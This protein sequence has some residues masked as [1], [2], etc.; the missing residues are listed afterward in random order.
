MTVSELEMETISSNESLI[1]CLRKHHPAAVM[2]L[3]DD[4][5][6]TM[7]TRID[8]ESLTPTENI[9]IVNRE[10]DAG[11]LLD[12][13]FYADIFLDMSTWDRLPIRY[14]PYDSMWVLADAPF[15][16]SSPGGS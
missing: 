12:A 11:E 3:E 8:R 2:T 5:Y 13:A 14:G 9:A 15:A 1:E 4:N 6:V 7:V 16:P 10:S